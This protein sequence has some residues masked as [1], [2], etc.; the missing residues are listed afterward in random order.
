MAAYAGIPDSEIQQLQ[1]IRTGES[2]FIFEILFLLTSGHC[3][4]KR[5]KRATTIGVATEPT[6]VA[7]ERKRTSFS[8]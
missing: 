7:T 3:N 2:V 4:H 1:T 8:S 6:D 5:T